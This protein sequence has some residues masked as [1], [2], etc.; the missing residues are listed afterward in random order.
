MTKL[1]WEKKNK[2]AKPKAKRNQSNRTK[3]L[4]AYEN[5]AKNER[6]RIIKKIRE[7]APLF[8]S[9]EPNSPAAT[10]PLEEMAN[11]IEGEYMSKR[12]ELKEGKITEDEYFIEYGKNVERIR[13]VDLFTKSDQEGFTKAQIRELIKGE[14][15]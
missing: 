4:K 12:Q 10:H 2:E 6:Q 1:N 11:L 3:V 7:Y 13:I 8:Y 9:A 15:K 14:Q 5:G